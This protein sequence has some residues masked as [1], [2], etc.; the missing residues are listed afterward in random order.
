MLVIVYIFYF[1]HWDVTFSLDA[2]C[3]GHV[4]WNHVAAY[5]YGELIILPVGGAYGAYFINIVY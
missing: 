4:F 3:S 5:L 2:N 1:I